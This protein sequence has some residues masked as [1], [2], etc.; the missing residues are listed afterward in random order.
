MSAKFT[1]KVI[2]EDNPKEQKT[3]TCTVAANGA[4]F[5]RLEEEAGK[6]FEGDYKEI[7]FN[8]PGK[9]ITLKNPK[10]DN[11]E[12]SSIHNNRKK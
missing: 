3:F 9:T 12:I 7:I 6:K 10:T 1:Y 4:A 8:H 11:N 2:C 5:T